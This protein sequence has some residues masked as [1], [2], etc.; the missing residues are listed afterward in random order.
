MKGNNHMKVQKIG[1]VAVFGGA[2]LA[3]LLGAGSAQAAP[4]ISFSGNGGDAVGVGDQN[5]GTGA[6]ASSGQVGNHNN[7]LAVS[8]GLS[9]VGSTAVANGS[10][11]NVVSIDGVAVTGPKTHDN[12]VVNVAGA[13][14]VGGKSDHNNVVTVAGV[15]S[16]G[17]K[18]H[19]NTVVNVGGVV[20]AQGA[21][22]QLS[23]SAC[24]TSLSGQAENIT[25]S[26]GACGG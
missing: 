14:V 12:N 18:S 1:A 16:V 8:T 17:G 7:A 5:P 11:N 24:G 10:H 19:D 23:L 9:P 15:T 4:G 22:S 13:T 3:G 20:Q 25:V 2:V 21:S 6:F 26:A